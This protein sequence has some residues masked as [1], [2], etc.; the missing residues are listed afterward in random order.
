MERKLIFGVK[1]TISLVLP[2]FPLFPCPVAIQRL[3]IRTGDAKPIVVAHIS[4]IQ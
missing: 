3:H 1:K 4:K 2:A